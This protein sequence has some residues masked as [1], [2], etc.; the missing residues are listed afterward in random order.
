MQDT[1]H[2]L[3]HLVRAQM[4]VFTHACLN[5]QSEIR[6]GE[7]GLERCARSGF[8]PWGS[9]WQ[10]LGSGSLFWHSF[11]TFSNIR[12]KSVLEKMV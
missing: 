10:R 5:F 6:F 1:V 12:K 4:C 3:A 8:P 11:L 7:D 2:V 9:H